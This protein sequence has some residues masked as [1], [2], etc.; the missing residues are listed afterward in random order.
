MTER[1]I[2]PPARPEDQ[3][4]DQER[5]L[6][7]LREILKNAIRSREQSDMA[8]KDVLTAIQAFR[9]EHKL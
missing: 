7:E 1:N 2:I 9:M 3:Y 6:A 4:Q 8:V 5:V